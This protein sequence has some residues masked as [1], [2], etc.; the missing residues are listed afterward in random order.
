ME[1]VPLVVD[2]GTGV[3]SFLEAECDKLI[4]KIVCKSR[5]CWLKLPRTWLSRNHLI[6]DSTLTM[7]QYFR[8]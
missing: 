1:G 3:S 5:I 8:R 4:T 6:Y 7:I 2:N